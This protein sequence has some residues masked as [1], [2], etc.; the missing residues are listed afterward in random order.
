MKTPSP[1]YANLSGF[2]LIELL[3]VI[4]IIGILAS[5]L[6]P[7]LAASKERARAAGCISN[8]RQIGLAMTIY[9]DDSHG[10]YPLS[11]GTILWSQIDPETQKGSWLQQIIG[12]AQNT[13][14]YRCPSDYKGQFSYFNG[15][16]AAYITESN[17]A[18]V[19]TKRIQFASAYVLS[20]DTLW[21]EAKLNDADKDDYS[22][23]CVGGASNGSRW[24]DWRRH[25]KG[26]NLL[27]ADNHVKWFKGYETKVMTFR[28][29][30]TH[31]WE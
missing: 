22:L 24:V 29:E 3:V 2:T 10:L 19:D 30:T 8:L 23:N 21:T 12:Y 5:L 20:G 14:A 1:K 7:T 4:A 6:L 27:F 18:S 9:A 26:Q 16:R 15:V 28:Y 31:G 17:F 25:S 11:G 13:N